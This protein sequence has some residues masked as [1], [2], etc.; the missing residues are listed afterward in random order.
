MFISCPIKL[1]YTRLSAFYLLVVFSLASAPYA[2]TPK[3]DVRSYIRENYTKREA[4]IP[5]RD[6]IRLFTIVYEPKD[7]SQKYPIMLTRTPFSV[8]PYGKGEDGADLFPGMLGPNPAFA[9]EG[10]IFVYQDVRGLWKSE[11]DF[12]HLRP[13]GITSRRPTDESTDAYDTVDWLV[14]NVSNNNGRVGI[15]GV[16]YPGFFTSAGII[17]THPAIKAASPQA[18]VSDSFMGDDLRHSGAVFL[19]Q[20]YVFYTIFDERS[21][22]TPND[23]SVFEPF[24]WPSMDGY[25]LFRNI[26]GLKEAGDNYEK[27]LGRRSKFWDEVSAHPNYDQFWKDRDILPKLKNIT[28]PVMVVGGWFDNED[29]YGTLQTYRHIHVQNPGIPTYLVVGP[30]SHNSWSRVDGDWLGTAYFG[31]KTAEDYRARFE[32]PF[33]NFYLKDKG[34]FSGVKAANLFDTGSN[35]WR[36][37]DDYDKSRITQT[38][39]YLTAAGKLSF[40][41][42]AGP[43]AS[44]EYVSDPMHPVPYTQKITVDYPREFM[45]EDQRFAATRP[46]VL[47][48]QTDVLTDD[49]TIAGDIGPELEV[50]TSGSDSD[51]VV[52]L[53]DVFPDNYAYPEG[54]KPPSDAASSVFSPGGYEML[55]RG[56]PFPAR[57]RNSFE[58]PEPMTPNVPTRISFVM[59]GIA[60]T[61]KKGHRIMVQV[62]ST[63]FPLV[64]RNPQKFVPNYDL[65][66]GSDFQKATQRVYLGGSAPSRLI[67]PVFK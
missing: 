7:R 39:L 54:V 49:V 63:W 16:S 20:N 13:E 25:N 9:G 55:L 3:Q 27:L 46:D 53:I 58:R 2:Q 1:I 22:L 32:L 19:A 38:P 11:G 66:T 23:F 43:T 30:W 21:R 44:D 5:M 18:P 52:K 6:G 28:T 62:Q 12:V 31:S 60:H 50:S 48:Y 14:K 42:P 17:N 33:F 8:A 51:F 47:V 34:D 40:A 57:F 61:F 64:A 37:M 45:T 35:T 56:E 26:G 59:P 67:L 4:F 65:A 29:L 15:Y 10:Y 24:V 41:R 36:A